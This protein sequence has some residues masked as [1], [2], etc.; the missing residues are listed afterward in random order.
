MNLNED[1][2][3]VSVIPDCED[4]VEENVKCKGL[5]VRL[6]IRVCEGQNGNCRM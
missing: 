2:G 3:Q 1:F 5:D 4:M 6:P